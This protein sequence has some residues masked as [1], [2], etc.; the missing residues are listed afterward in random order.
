MTANKR[1]NQ[2]NKKSLAYNDFILIAGNIS[3]IIVG[4]RAAKM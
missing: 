2:Q 1:K 3:G 4:R